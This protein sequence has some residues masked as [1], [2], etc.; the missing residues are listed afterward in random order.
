[1]LRRKNR[2]MRAGRVEEA[3]A[4]AERVGKAVT[5]RSK[6]RLCRID[7]QHG[8]KA[9]WEALRQMTGRRQNVSVVDGVSADSLNEHYAQ[10][11]TDDQA[12]VQ[13]HGQRGAV[14][15][16]SEWRVFQS[17]D[18]LRPTVTGLDQLSAWFLRLG[19]PAFAKPLSYLVNLSIAT[20]TV[21][22]Q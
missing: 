7:R 15:Y 14:E 17:L 19:A 5:R 22:T 4:L 13:V 10:I 16:I 21:P 2:L 6:K 3:G 18:N 12:S 9:M 11:S 1:M 8:A 20:S